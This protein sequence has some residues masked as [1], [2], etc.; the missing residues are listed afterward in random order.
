MNT[1]LEQSDLTNQSIAGF[2]ILHRL[3]VGGMSEV[4]LAFQESLRRHVAIKVMRA[5]FVGSN[6]H[7][8]RF[9]Q[10]ARAVASLIHPNIVQVYDVGK[11]ETIHYIAQE[12]VPGSNLFSYVQR[13]G[14]LP[15]AESVSIL[16]QTTAALQKAASI[17]LVH[18]DIKP[19]AFRPRAAVSGANRKF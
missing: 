6:D 4:Y 9:L 8:Q 10:E 2:S 5:D 3:G 16:W 1:N 13:R 14:A 11:F 18:R 12:Y 7:E 19:C 15:L 17:G